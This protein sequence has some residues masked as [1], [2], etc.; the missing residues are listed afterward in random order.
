MRRFCV[1]AWVL[2]V[3]TGSCPS[4]ASN[5]EL[6]Q[7]VPVETNLAE[8]GLRTAQQAWIAEIQAA[9]QSIDMGHFYAATA[10][11]EALS[12]VIDA[13]R[14]AGTRGVHIRMMISNVLYNDS[15]PTLRILKTIPNFELRVLNLSG[16]TGGIIHTKY[17][18][19]DRAKAIVG[20][21]NFDWRSLSHIHE[22]GLLT[23]DANVVAPLVSIFEMDWQGSRPDTRDKKPKIQD[24][25]ATA[26]LVAS[27]RSMLPEGT[28]WS[29]TQL[30]QLLRSARTEI[31]VQTLNF[32]T[33]ERG[34]AWR[35]IENELRAAAARG[36]QVR[37]LVSDW[38]LRGNKFE[39][40]HTLGAVPGITVRV[41]FIPEASR[42]PIPYARVIHSKYMVIDQETLFL[43]TSNLEKD[44]FYNSRNVE[45]IL[46]KPDTALQAHSVF[47]RLWTSEYVRDVRNT[48]RQP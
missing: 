32:S 41:A 27:P 23:N 20:S 30:L 26:E 16:S 34:G 19:F 12:S 18:I 24:T 8:P 33:H 36:V 11:G 42:G 15:E 25:P 29:L 13:L 46:R 1:T 3:I 7:T 17:W 38:N 47:Q 44:Y 6:I 4:W 5:Y 21:Q 35:E 14:E 28:E 39:S 9:R 37:L 40:I 43:G 45:I 10:D 48:T 31:E 2:G 22:M